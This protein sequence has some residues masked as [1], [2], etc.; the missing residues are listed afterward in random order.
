MKRISSSSLKKEE[1][2]V[3]EAENSESG[4]E[5]LGEPPLSLLYSTALLHFSPLMLHYQ[6]HF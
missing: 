4:Y 6:T 1:F 5:P 2:V 3:I